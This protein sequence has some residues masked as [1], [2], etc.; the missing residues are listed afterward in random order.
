M[1]YADK[2]KQKE[3]QRLWMQRRRQDWFSEHGPCVD[4]GSRENL[5]LDHIDPT[6]KITH[7]VWSWRAERR[8]KELS[9][10]TVR[11]HSCHEAKTNY[12]TG[13]Q[14]PHG[15]VSKYN[16]GCHCID[17]RKAELE[18]WHQRDQSYRLRK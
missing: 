9:K 8:D 18:R 5:E 1:P 14:A 11:C 16:S 17:C 2:E 6:Q 12:Q 13:R 15:T 4:C 10:C 7:R 3:Y